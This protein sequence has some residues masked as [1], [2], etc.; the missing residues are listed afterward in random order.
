MYYISTSLVR[1]PIEKK[2]KKPVLSSPDQPNK[3]TNCYLRIPFLALSLFTPYFL[4]NEKICVSI[5][6]QQEILQYTAVVLLY[7]LYA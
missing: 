1:A 2:N 7:V 6:C 3:I 5:P 4:E